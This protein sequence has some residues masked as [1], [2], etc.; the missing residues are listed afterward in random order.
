VATG[1]YLSRK[2]LKAPKLGRKKTRIFRRLARKVGFVSR[3]L[4]YGP[5]LTMPKAATSNYQPSVR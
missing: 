3:C 2:L 4:T 5:H 1:F